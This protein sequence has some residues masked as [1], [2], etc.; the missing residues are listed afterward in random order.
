MGNSNLIRK[1]KQR[2]LQLSE[3]L[4]LVD[5]G[6]TILNKNYDLKNIK[7]VLNKKIRQFHNC[8]NQINV[9]SFT[10]IDVI[11]KFGL[12]PKCYL[13]GIEINY[14]DSRSYNFDHIIPRSKGGGYGLE[15]MGL[16]LQK[17][18]F[19]KSDLML[20][21]FIELCESILVNRGY[22]LDRPVKTK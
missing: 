15:N 12:H 2:G 5:Y 11:R 19:A 8:V 10:W 1:L 4:F 18:N 21:E 3:I 20:P 13:T 16:C 17:A 9:K 22:R 6:E 14:E 7:A